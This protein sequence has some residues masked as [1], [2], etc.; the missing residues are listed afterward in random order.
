MSLNIRL[1][2]DCT[3]FLSFFLDEF[4]KS[5]LICEIPCA[6]Y[7][8]ICFLQF[9]CTCDLVVDLYSLVPEFVDQMIPAGSF[10]ANEC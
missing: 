6:L 3:L 4:D 5:E 1:G 8:S 7:N 10:Q 9:G 2:T